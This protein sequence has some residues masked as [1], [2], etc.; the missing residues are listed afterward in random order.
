MDFRPIERGDQ[1][2]FR[3]RVVHVISVRG[4]KALVQLAGARWEV[5]LGELTLVAD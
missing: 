5:P 3:S 2:L 1:V 4:G